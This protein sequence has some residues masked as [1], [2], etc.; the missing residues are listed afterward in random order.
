MTAAITTR[1]NG[2]AEMAFTGERR[3]I[4]HGQGQQLPVGASI[5]EWQAAAGMDWRIARSRV[6]YGEA[7]NQYVIEDQH[8]LFRSDNKAALGIVSDKYKVVQPG[9]VLEFFRDLLPVGYTL[10][11]AGTL[12]GGKKFWALAS[13]GE[14]A[15][16]VGRDAIQ[17][18]LLLTSSADGS[19]RTT[20]RETTTRVVCQ[21]TLSIAMAGKSP[22][23]VAISHR[24]AFDPKVIKDRLGLAR[25]HFHEFMLQARMLASRPVK[26]DEANQFLG[27][28]LVETKAVFK[29]DVTKSKPFISIMDLFNGQGAGATMDGVDGTLWGLLNG[30]TE[31]VDH[32]ARAKTAENRLDSA[33]FG[34]GEE[35]KNRAFQKALTL[36]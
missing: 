6:R 2:F 33:W 8:V 34:R 29:E 30:V 14:T 12:H 18:Y 16:V 31:Y 9:E 15:V 13:I 28:L 22:N 11:T 27:E 7:P 10:S 24:S 36:A 23:E 5:E 20:A 17:G 26:Q 4:W 3:E 32:H 21:N 19:T 35:V 1:K 25:G